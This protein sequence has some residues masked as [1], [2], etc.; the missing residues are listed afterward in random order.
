MPVDEE[1]FDIEDS[2]EQ[3]ALKLRLAEL[4]D[5]HRALDS[6]IMALVE[7]GGDQLQAAR[8]KREKLLLKDQISWIENQLTPDIIA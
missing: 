6:A 4:R 8:L 2:P 5:K 7:A 1:G 3:R